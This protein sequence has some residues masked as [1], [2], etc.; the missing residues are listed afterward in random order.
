MTT[1]EQQEAWDDYERRH[2]CG[3]T[4]GVLISFV[5]FAVVG[6]LLGFGCGHF[7]FAG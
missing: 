4:G 3:M 7:L 5:V 2:Q 6:W 1:H